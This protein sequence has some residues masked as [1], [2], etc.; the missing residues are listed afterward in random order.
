VSNP[1]SP[2]DGPPNIHP[3][4]YAPRP[5]GSRWLWQLTRWML[6]AAVATLS[7]VVA[8]Q[9]IRQAAVLYWQR[10]C[11]NYPNTGQ[12]VNFAFAAGTQPS[13]WTQFLL[14]SNVG[15]VP[16]PPHP[17]T[18]PYQSLYLGH[19]KRPDGADRVVYVAVTCSNCG[20]P[21]TA[22]STE[23]V[24]VQPATVTRAAQ[25]LDVG[26]AGGFF[27]GD[28]TPTTSPTIHG[29]IL[30]P[31]DPS[32]FTIT[33]TLINGQTSILDGFLDNNDTL[34]IDQRP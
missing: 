9:A 13:A 4:N 27:L 23:Y 31:A 6:F 5:P 25:I 18:P 7:L 3:L 33:V 14:A 2:T 28:A 26:G 8:K 34:H 17:P 12:A 1:N 16:P 24:I 15:Q 10:Q 20:P 32:H 21:E 19:M 11:L 30:D 22:V 29:A